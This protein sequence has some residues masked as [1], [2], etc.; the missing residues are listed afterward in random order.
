MNLLSDIITYVRRLIKSPSN[1][2]IT[3]NLIIDYINRFWLLDVDARIQLFDL[4]TDYTFQTVPGIASYNMPLYNAQIEPGSQTIA[5]F[6]VYQ[7][8]SQPAFVNGIQV[9]F[10]TQENSFWNLWPNY[11]QYLNP[12]AVGNGTAGPY[13][14]PL[15]EAPAIP[16]Y[17]DM[18]GII[19]IINNGGSNTDPIFTTTIPPFPSSPIIP[20]SSFHSGVRFTATDATGNNMTV[21]DTGIFLS[22]SNNSQLYGLLITQNTSGFGYGAPNP[23]NYQIYSTYSQTQNTVNYTTGSATVTFPN[24]VPAG[25]SINA[26][27]LFFQPGLPRAILFYNNC[28]QI[29]PTPDISYAVQ[30]AGYLTPAA[31]LASGN[32]IPFGY[33][34]E[35][36][37]RGAARKI[38]SDTGDIEQFQFYEPLFKEQE[39]LVWKRSQRQFTASR[40]ATIF[41]DLQGQTNFNQIGAGN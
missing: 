39:I 29:R 14:I 11:V 4:K 24:D 28:M 6:P 2:V 17:L 34:S 10:Y 40:T 8:F 18:T 26:E 25:S 38:L 9:P 22:G 41:S 23:Y 13:T 33:M 15:A 35:Y 1:A 37:A 30:V 27:C 20:F 7:G 36:I 21:Q 12:A 19:S 16:G 31:F 32:A 3:D 5:S